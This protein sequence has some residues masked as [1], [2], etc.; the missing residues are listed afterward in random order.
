LD[1]D[2]TPGTGSTLTTDGGRARG[3]NSRQK[4][5]RPA[6]RDQLRLLSI[7]Q[8]EGKEFDVST[9]STTFNVL[10]HLLRKSMELLSHMN[11]KILTDKK[12]TQ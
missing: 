5:S 2:E 3:R 1:K 9:T 12:S 10:L 4:R 6:R 7:K 8:K 11:I